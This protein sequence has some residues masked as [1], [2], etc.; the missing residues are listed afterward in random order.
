MVQNVVCGNAICLYD[1]R[2]SFLLCVSQKL[3][4]TTKHQPLFEHGRELM[5][6]MA[7]GAPSRFEC[8]SVNIGGFMFVALT[9]A[10]KRREAPKMSHTQF[11]RSPVCSNTNMVRKTKRRS[12]NPPMHI[13]IHGTVCTCSTL[14]EN[15]GDYWEISDVPLQITLMNISK[16]SPLHSLY[17]C[18]VLCTK[19]HLLWS[20]FF[21][22]LWNSCK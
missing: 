2:N 21:P 7:W 17:V 12:N 6:L 9:L 13:D 11:L 5:A 8:R 16:L 19:M 14:W 15:R 10:I 22:V 3:T 18:V 20:A 1:A 4:S